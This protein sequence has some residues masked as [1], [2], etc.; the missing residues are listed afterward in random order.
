MATQLNLSEPSDSDQ[1]SASDQ[2]V[3]SR[4]SSRVAEKKKG[5]S[6]AEEPF[7]LSIKYFS[8]GRTRPTHTHTRT[9]TQTDGGVTVTATNRTICGVLC[10]SEKCTRRQRGVSLTRVCKLAN[11][12][13]VGNL[14]F[15]CLST[16]DITRCF[17]CDGA[18]ETESS[19]PLLLLFKTTT[20]VS[21]NSSTDI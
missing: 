13:D 3:S 16:F 4:S 20:T 6:E 11:T 7:V 5:K 2:S 18:L 21:C 19:L 9:Q 10:H 14:F 17:L 15:F 12:G 1:S 8:K